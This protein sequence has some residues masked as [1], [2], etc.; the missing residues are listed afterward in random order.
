M[1]ACRAKRTTIQQLDILRAA[2]E[3]VLSDGDLLVCILSWAASVRTYTA[4]RQLNKAAR[5]ACADNKALLREVALH[6]AK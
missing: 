6:S 1:T 3:D 4:V 2:A 5:A